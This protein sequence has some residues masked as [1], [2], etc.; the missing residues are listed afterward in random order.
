MIAVIWGSVNKISNDEYQRLGDRA[1]WH[2]IGSIAQTAG[3]ECVNPVSQS[4]LHS[5]NLVTFF[6]CW[7]LF[8][9]L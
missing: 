5:T 3:L 9:S 1:R 4:L 2:V 6:N 7:K 8:L